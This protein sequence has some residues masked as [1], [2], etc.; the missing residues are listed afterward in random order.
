M[1]AEDESC[2]TLQT[3]P[4][5]GPLTALSFVSVMDG[6]ARFA[7]SWSVGAYLGLSPRS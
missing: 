7:K 4:G 5:V 1:A 6:P 2:W 3:M